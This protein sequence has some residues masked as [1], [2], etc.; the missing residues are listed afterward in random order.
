[1]DQS[2]RT[3]TVEVL[4]ENPERLLKPGFFAKGM[5]LTQR[6][7]NVLAIPEE[8]ISTLAGVTAVF[9]E[10]NHKVRQQ[11][12]SLGAREG[13]FVEVISGLKG[14]ETLASSNLSQLATG[15]T[16]R[17]AGEHAEGTPGTGTPD[18]KRQEGQR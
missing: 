4:V 17:P 2:T 7:E 13:R 16:V 1:V 3:F 15:I 12:V 11:I 6:D 14:N 18:G 9:V 5:I 8:A 10:E